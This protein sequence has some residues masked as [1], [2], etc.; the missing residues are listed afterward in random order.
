[1]ITQTVAHFGRL[2]TLIN[3]ASITHRS[4]I[5]T[6]DA[7]AFDWLMGLNLR[8]MCLISGHMNKKSIGTLYNLAS[9]YKMRLL[10]VLMVDLEMNA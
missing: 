1:M 8:D 5:D 4:T 3:N 2:D 9:Q 10:K 6:T 7:E